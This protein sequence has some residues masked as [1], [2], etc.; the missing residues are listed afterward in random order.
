MIPPF[1]SSFRTAG[2]S[3]RTSSF[4]TGAGFKFCMGSWSSKISSSAFKIPSAACFSTFSVLNRGRASSP[5]A[6]GT[7]FSKR[8]PL[9]SG[10][11]AGGCPPALA[12]VGGVGAGLPSGC[13]DNP[14]VVRSDKTFLT[15]S[16]FWL[17][18]SIL[19][20][21][22]IFCDCFSFTFCFIDSS[23]ACDLGAVVLG[24]GSFLSS[25]GWL[26]APFLF[27]W[28]GLSAGVRSRCGCCATVFSLA[29]ISVLGALSAEEREAS[30]M[31]DPPLRLLFTWGPVPERSP[32][33]SD[34]ESEE[35]DEDEDEDES[36]VPLLPHWA[37]SESE[38]CFL[39]GDRTFWGNST[40]VFLDK[41]FG[42]PWS[43]CSTLA[44]GLGL[45]SVLLWLTTDGEEVGA[46]KV[47]DT[48]SAVGGE[49]C[50]PLSFGS[51]TSRKRHKE[52]YYFSYR[53]KQCEFIKVTD[54]S[55]H[56]TLLLT[57]S[58]TSSSYELLHGN[59]LLTESQA[60]KEN[61]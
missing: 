34:S 2:F 24:L 42:S 11:G 41:S 3:S 56:I 50:W 55:L 43:V 29:D 25:R 19:F 48:A 37:A 21:L 60:T 23:A 30:A 38:P 4:W 51:T 17:S 44:S 12:P 58:S 40:K 33:S 16:G 27:A 22:D 5:S 35:L 18:L 1:S 8:L 10:G 14:H 7:F 54:I 52:D 61:N 6:S 39:N 13:V 47:L 59:P 45:A 36:S 32:S 9:A 57:V 20:D 31:G 26:E 28:R 49:S 53:V 46:D 15:S